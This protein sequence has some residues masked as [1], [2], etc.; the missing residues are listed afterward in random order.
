MIMV[1]VIEKKYMETVI[2]MGR[3]MQDNETDWEQRR[4]DTARDCMA[5]LLSN[6]AIV[7]GVTEDGEPVWEAPVAIARAAVELADVLIGQ[8]KN[9]GHV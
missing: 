9:G 6:P 2:A 8:L 5:A 4:Y 7:D 3:R 1:S